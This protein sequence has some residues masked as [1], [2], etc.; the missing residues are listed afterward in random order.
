MRIILGLVG[1]AAVVIISLQLV[2]NY[3]RTNPPI[4][5]QLTWNSPETDQLMRQAC[6]DCHS[7][8]TIW[9]W[10]SNIAPVSWLVVKDVN[11]GRD[12]LN[13]STGRGEMEAG[14][15]IEQIE[16]G[17]MPP[18]IYLMMH[19]D[20]NLTDIQKADLIAGIRASLQG[21]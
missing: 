5:F 19:S 9:P 3:E 14:E 1:V 10:Y 12:K 8:E 2:P 7:N 21:D 4:T 13:F 17:T 20:A 11:E 15:L 16:R 18:K 6:Y